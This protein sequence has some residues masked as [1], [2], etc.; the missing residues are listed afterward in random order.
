VLRC[1]H[2]LRLKDGIKAVKGCSTAATMAAAGGDKQKKKRPLFLVEAASPE[3]VG[4]DDVCDGVED[5][6]DV[7]GVGGTGHVTV[8]LLGRRLVLGLELSLNVGRRLTI[9]LSTCVL[10]ET[11]GEGGSEDFLFE[12]IF[13][14]EEEDDGGVAEPLVVADGVEELQRLLHPV[15][16]FVLV[17]DL[18]VLAHRHAENDGRHVL[19]TMD[20]F[21]TLGSLTAHIKQLEI[22]VFER[23]VDFDDAGGFDSCP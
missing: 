17:Q 15:G 6:L 7:L 3:V 22:E 2:G 14:V 13:F 4:D 16:R 23:K 18:V 1:R 20:P 5:E 19:E 8:D 11:D 9:L 10:C 12:E 21:L